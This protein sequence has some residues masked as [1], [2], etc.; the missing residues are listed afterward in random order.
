M[1]N[2]GIHQHRF[3]DN[4]EERRFAEAWEKYNSDGS[5]FELID[6]VL[7]Q[8]NNRPEPCSDRDREVAATVIQ[9]LG[10]PVGQGF[11]KELGYSTRKRRHPLWMD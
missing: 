8:N 6:Y 5:S 11:L 9:W 10:S 7:S 3:R 4:Q 2:K 1:K